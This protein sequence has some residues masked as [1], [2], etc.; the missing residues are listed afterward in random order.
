MLFPNCRDDHYYNQDFLD[1]TDAQ[2]LKGFD[3]A[4]EMTVDNFFDNNMFGLQDEDGYLAHTLNDKIP[5]PI[6][7]KYAIESANKFNPWFE[8]ERKVITYADL[9]RI[10]LLEWVEMHRNELITSMIDNMDDEIY[11][12]LRN[13]TLKDNDKK[14]NPKQYYDTRHHMF[15]NEIVSDGPEENTQEEG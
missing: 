13:K 11:T 4:I 15:T 7:I 12:A 2:F 3:W 9:I 10:K 5:E 1:G 8:E 14:E 6:Q